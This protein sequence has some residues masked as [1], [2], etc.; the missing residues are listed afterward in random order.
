MKAV[1]THSA[2]HLHLEQHLQVLLKR[3]QPALTVALRV[4]FR[5]ADAVQ[6]DKE[7]TAPAQHAHGPH[8]A[9]EQK[10][11]PAKDINPFQKVGKQRTEKVLIE[12]H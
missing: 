9:T 8:T 5:R 3:G 1:Y 4:R 6:E 10:R 2:G 11:R 7:L 12:N